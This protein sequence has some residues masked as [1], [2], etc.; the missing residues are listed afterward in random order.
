[1]APTGGEATLLC[2]GD[3]LLPQLPW[4]SSLSAQVT[5]QRKEGD[6]PQWGRASPPATARQPVPTVVQHCQV[7]ELLNHSPL[8]LDLIGVVLWMNKDRAKIIKCSKQSAC[9]FEGRCLLHMHEPVGFIW[10]RGRLIVKTTFKSVIITSDLGWNIITRNC[11][12]EGSGWS[13]ISWA[14]PVWL[15]VSRCAAASQR[16]S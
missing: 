9:S 2:T 16:W 14:N 13:C 4:A 15:S 10:C 6:F 3:I 5:F 8:M 12:P 7:A 11:A 1:M